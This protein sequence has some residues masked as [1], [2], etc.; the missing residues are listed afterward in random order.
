METATT[1][2]N[3]YNKRRILPLTNPISL[4]TQHAEV[5][6]ITIN[7]TLYNAKIRYQFQ[8]L[9]CGN[10]Q[11]FDSLFSFQ[12][13]LFSINIKYVSE[14]VIKENLLRTRKQRSHRMPA[15]HV[16]SMMFLCKRSLEKGQV[17]RF[18][19]SS[20]FVSLLWADPYPPSPCLL[21]LSDIVCRHCSHVALAC[22]FMLLYSG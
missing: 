14:K 5:P 11:Y 15:S 1:E 7:K 20:F 21:R 12:Y 6:L 16:D 2:V 4:D 3:L 13:V 19:R 9:S 8:I 22:F 10:L 18:K 17:S